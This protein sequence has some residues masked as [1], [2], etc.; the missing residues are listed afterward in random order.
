MP[1]K[2]LPGPAGLGTAGKKLFASFKKAAW[3]TATTAI[4]FLLPLIIEMD[5][6]Q[7]IEA[8]E[9]DQMNVLT[10]GAKP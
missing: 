8:M 7:Q 5:R 10:G 2:A 3:I 4:I 1:P 9:R 6:E